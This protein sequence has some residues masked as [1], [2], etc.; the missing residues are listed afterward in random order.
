MMEIIRNTP[1]LRFHAVFK[2][3]RLEED[4]IP[5]GYIVWDYSSLST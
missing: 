5:T 4:V 1:E 3:N 2:L